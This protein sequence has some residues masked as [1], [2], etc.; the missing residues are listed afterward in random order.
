MEAQV[1]EPD[2]PLIGRHPV[3]ELLRADSRRVEVAAA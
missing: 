1:T 3:L 2:P